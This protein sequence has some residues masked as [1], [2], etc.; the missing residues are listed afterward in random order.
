VVNTVGCL[1]S[2]ARVSSL[3]PCRA[4]RLLPVVV[5]PPGTVVTD[6]G[7]PVPGAGEVVEGPDPTGRVVSPGPPPSPDPRRKKKAM[8]NMAKRAITRPRSLA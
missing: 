3:T 1:R 6:P 5:V 8:K 4:G 7:S 2:W